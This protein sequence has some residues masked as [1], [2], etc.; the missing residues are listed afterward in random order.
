M[1]KKVMVDSHGAYIRTNG[2]VYR[3]QLSTVVFPHSK[4][5]LFGWEEIAFP[6]DQEVNAS[7]IK[8]SPLLKVASPNGTYDI[9][10][11]HGSYFAIVNNQMAGQ[12]TSEE[13]W[14]PATTS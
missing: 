13:V 4:Q 11:T 12:F 2:E 1:K 8:G 5:Y 3:P 9:W 7:I 10:Y 14:S 6:L